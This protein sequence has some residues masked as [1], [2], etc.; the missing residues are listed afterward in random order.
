MNKFLMSACAV[1]IGLSACNQQKEVKVGS[2]ACDAIL[3]KYHAIKY[4]DVKSADGS[5]K[6]MIV[7][8]WQ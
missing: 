4:V 7:P 5:S 8:S 1:L 6:V 2:D 3:L